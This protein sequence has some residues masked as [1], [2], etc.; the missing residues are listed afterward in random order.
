MSGFSLTLSYDD[1]DIRATMTRLR[2][3]GAD[4]REEVLTPVGATLEATTV[5]RFDTNVGPDGEAWEPSLRASITGGR[6]L[7][8]RGHLRDSIH[9]VLE[10][11]AVEIGSADIRAGV[12]QF[13]AVIHAKTSAGLNF[14]LA[15]GLGVTVDS[16]QMPE[17]PFVGLS[18]ED[19]QLVIGIGQAAL[20]RALEGRK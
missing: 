5:E 19:G 2:I 9:Y 20:A 11:D 12:H 6:T 15:D 3:L 1:L 10:D 4:L 17:R 14:T 18:A 13:G 16:V 7:V 8:E